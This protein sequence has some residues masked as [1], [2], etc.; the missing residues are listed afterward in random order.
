MTVPDFAADLTRAAATPETLGPAFRLTATFAVEHD[1]L[2]PDVAYRA[3]PI[4]LVSRA[5]RRWKRGWAA[6]RLPQRKLH[7]RGYAPH[8]GQ[9]PGPPGPP[10]VALGADQ[11]SA[12]E[13]TPW[14]AAVPAAKFPL[15][16]AGGVIVISVVSHIGHLFWFVVC[17]GKTPGLTGPLYTRQYPGVLNRA[18]ACRSGLSGWLKMRAMR[19]LATSRDETPGPASVSSSHSSVI[20][21]R[22]PQLQSAGEM[23]VPAH[24]VGVRPA[25]L[26]FPGPRDVPG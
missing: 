2:L 4:P 6:P 7:V 18:A 17:N 23:P 20:R 14:L 11:E 3:P 10:H 25:G 9:R 15:V 13:P 26:V 24:L 12:A 5:H 1:G 8:D 19:E 16:Q 22:D 21:G